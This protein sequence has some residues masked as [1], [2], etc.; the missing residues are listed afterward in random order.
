MNKCLHTVASSW[1]FLLTLNHDAWN[2]EF[3]KNETKC[4]NLIDNQLQFSTLLP[5]GYLSREDARLQFLWTGS[6]CCSPST[7][8]Y[9]LM[10]T[11]F[12]VSSCFPCFACQGTLQCHS[13]VAT[14]QLLHLHE[15]FLTLNTSPFTNVSHTNTTAVRW[16][17]HLPVLTINVFLAGCASLP[18][19]HTPPAEYFRYKT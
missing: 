1:T 13:A 14:P 19:E 3:K 16:V 15:R 2:H 11:L 7:W 9:S 6:L 8:P 4:V 18:T 10:S 5:R 12:T 17:R